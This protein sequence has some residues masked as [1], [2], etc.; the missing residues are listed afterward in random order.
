M[1][2]PLRIEIAFSE[3]RRIEELGDFD[4]QSLAHLVDNAQLYGIVVAVNYVANRRL[5]HAALHKQLILRHFLFFE[6]FRQSFADCL[7]ELHYITI[8]V[9][10]LIF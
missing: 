3:Q 5:R 8:P 7:I 6:Q 4:F 10:V 1:P 9:A 2:E